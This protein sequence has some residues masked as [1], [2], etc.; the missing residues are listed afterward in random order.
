MSRALADSGLDV[1][2][3]PTIYT[4]VPVLSHARKLAMIHDVI[5]ETFPELT[6]PT[7]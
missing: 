7:P 1:L 2:F 5:P 6:L 4:Y 3:F